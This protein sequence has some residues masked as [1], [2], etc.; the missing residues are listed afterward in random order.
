MKKV[1]SVLSVIVSVV[2]GIHLSDKKDL[3]KY[4]PVNSDPSKLSD[5]F[6]K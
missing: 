2:V 6:K 5:F 3:F 4:C 1:F